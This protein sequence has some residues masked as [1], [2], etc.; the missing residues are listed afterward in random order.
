M[1]KGDIVCFSVGETSR[2]ICR[3]LGPGEEKE[4]GQGWDYIYILQ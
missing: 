3:S 1:K 2:Q 4:H